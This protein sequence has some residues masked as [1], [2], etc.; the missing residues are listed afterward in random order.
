MAVG[1]LGRPLHSARLHGEPRLQ[2]R[3]ELAPWFGSQWNVAEAL[4]GMQLEWGSIVKLRMRNLSF[5]EVSRE[6]TG[7]EASRGENKGQF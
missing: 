3:T 6:E 4:C 2:V 1:G 7:G 5:K